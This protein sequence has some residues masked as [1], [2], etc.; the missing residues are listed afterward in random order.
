ME[1][2]RKLT[3][4]EETPFDDDFEEN[5]LDNP[6]KI[7]EYLRS[8][9]YKQDKACKAAAMILYNHIHGKITSRNFFCGNGCHI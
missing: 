1:E 4:Y 7:Y 6:R 8:K 3:A 9:V 5:V 2:W